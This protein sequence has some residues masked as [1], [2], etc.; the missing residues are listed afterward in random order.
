MRT[1]TVIEY[2]A[3]D[4]TAK[5]DA[6]YSTSD[7]QDFSDAN[8]LK[9]DPEEI[10]YSTL[11][12]NYFLLDGSFENLPDNIGNIGYWSKTTSSQTRDFT[13]P[14]TLTITFAH[15]HSSIGLT[16]RFSQ[17]S[18]CT[19]LKI[20]YY[21][22]SDTLIHEEEY[23]PD[24]Y[25][26]FYEYEAVNYRKI[27]LTFYSTNEPNRYIKLYKVL[28]GRTVVFE[29][30]NLISA[31]IIE[32]IDPL[33]DE[34][35]INTLDFVCFATDDRFNIL[36]PQ[37]A[38]LTFQKTQPLKAYKVE[39]GITTDMGTFYLESWENESE[40]SMKIK[41]IDLIGILDKSEFNGGIYENKNAEQLIQEIMATANIQNYTISDL[42]SET[43]TGYLPI[44]TC[45]D[46]LQQVLFV[47][48]AV[49]DC[50]RSES[51]NIYKMSESETPNEIASDQIIQNTKEIT[52]GEIIT[53]VSV[54]THRYKL[55]REVETL[56]E[57]DLSQGTYKINFDTPATNLTIENAT[58]VESG[59]NYA[60]INATGSGSQQSRKYYG[61]R[62][63]L[64]EG[65]TYDDLTNTITVTDQEEY[66]KSNVLTINNCTLINSTNANDVATRVF[67]YYKSLYTNK[68]DMILDD[69]KVG[70]NVITEK[71]DINELNGYVTKLDIDMTGGFI[72]SAEIIA[73]VSE[74]NE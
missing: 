73:K 24:T 39:N 52:Q 57:E 70:D 6:Q 48:G 13:T 33:S 29:G 4:L 35:S 26:Y 20:A 25:E 69:E 58:I 49:A 27:I 32:E 74:A 10:K 62:T 65:N 46:A 18:Y 50:S 19:H 53:G 34:L 55:K 16:L 8:N 45:R 37:G 36:N 28:Y 30:D 63:V 44:S 41:G 42:T 17:Y 21:D 5:A 12:N 51:I 59:V 43:I 60:I 40:K 11:E 68:F 14:I 38:Y 67:N 64:I 56:Y 72:A 31:S 22:S 7:I 61:N 47:L 2:G 3:M 66:E 1:K 54:K 71:S 23:H 15:N 9:N